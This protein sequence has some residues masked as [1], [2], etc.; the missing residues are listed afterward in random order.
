MSFMKTIKKTLKCQVGNEKD[1][2]GLYICCCVFGNFL[3][4]TSANE[5]D[6]LF[7]RFTNFQKTVSCKISYLVLNFLKLY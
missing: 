1:I 7:T 4:K 6:G 3:P 2:I 5:N